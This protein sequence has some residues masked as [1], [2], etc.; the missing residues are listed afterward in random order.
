MGKW[1]REEEKE[2]S[3]DELE[4]GVNGEERSSMIWVEGK[5][6]KTPKELGMELGSTWSP[7]V[8]VFAGVLQWR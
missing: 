8:E 2:R 4:R 5:R 3:W 6:I 1:E 7:V